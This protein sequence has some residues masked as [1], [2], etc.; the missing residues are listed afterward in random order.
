[1]KLTV[2]QF[3]QIFPANQHA[4]EWVT[5]LNAVLPR[6]EITSA[7]RIAVFLAQC[8]HESGGFN[9][10]VEN[11]NYSADRL[12]KVFPKYFTIAQAHQYA[13]QQEAI[14]NRVYANRMGNGNEDSGDGWRYRGH[15]LLQLTGKDNH[16]GFAKSIGK[17]IQEAAAYMLTPAGAVESACY[18]WRIRNINAPADTDGVED[19]TRRING[20][21][22]GLTERK[23]L[24]AK[25]LKILR[26]KG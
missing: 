1:M 10:L 13:R 3:K 15:G 2:E 19:E 8:G 24:T 5:A 11:L 18:Y 14:A 21:A 6:Y 16:Q 23:A 22:N 12:L 25:A 9:R 26:A 4:D 20:G 7:I 17:T